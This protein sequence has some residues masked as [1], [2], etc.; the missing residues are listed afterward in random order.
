M[1]ELTSGHLED[2]LATVT[3]Q[4]M[5]TPG[6]LLYVTRRE[7]PSFLATLLSAWD[8]D[9]RDLG[10]ALSHELGQQR[11]RMDFYRDLRERLGAAWENPVAFKGLEVAGRYPPPLLRYMNDLDYWVPE[12]ERLWRIV[13]WLRDDGWSVHSAT[14]LRFEEDLHFIV[15]L[16][17][18]PD[19]PYALPYGVELGTLALLGDRVGVP[20]RRDLPEACADP[21]AKNLVALL[22]ERFE[23]PYRARDLV[24]A[25]VLLGDAPLPALKACALAV[26]ELALWP[27]YAEL[28]SLLEA[29]G[30]AVPALPGD[31]RLLTRAGQARRRVRAASGLRRPLNLALTS[32]QNRMM[33]GGSGALARR[34]WGLAE[35]RLDTRAAL[36]AGLLLFALPVEGDHHAERATLRE[37]GGTLWADTP[38][39]GFVLV[40][41]EEVDESALEGARATG[42]I[43]ETTRAG[44]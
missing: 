8:R 16:R 25:A 36:D 1:I 35:R 3:G 43:G 17:R 14:F 6:E 10:P 27:E 41:G 40:H 13:S 9:G 39:G 33:D 42:G 29:T 7:Q 19:D 31:L 2:V 18:L 44:E 24:D 12:E 23:Q 21:I 22:F 11:T 37:R 38:V 20:A 15:S 28:A 4:E 32:L 30:P 34:V 5:E 26:H